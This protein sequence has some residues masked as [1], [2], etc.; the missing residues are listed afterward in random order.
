MYSQK[1]EE[2]AILAHFG[3]SA[4]RLLDI[5]AWAPD[6]FSNTRA[7]L[8]RGWSGVLVEPSPKPFVKLL[9]QHSSN[10]HVRLLNAAVTVNGGISPFYDSDGDALSSTNP[11]HVKK[12]ATGKCKVKFTEYAV[13]TISLNSLF[14]HYGFDFDFINIDVEGCSFELFERLPFARLTKTTCICVEHDERLTSVIQTGSQW[15]FRVLM[16]NDENAILER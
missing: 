1:N 8:D 13:L 10:P 9:E 7:L 6:T 12:W 15:G 4:G 3:T 16:N 14:D 11:A 5:G 2:T